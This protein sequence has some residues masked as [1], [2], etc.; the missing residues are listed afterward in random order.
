MHSKLRPFVIEIV[1]C[2]PN[3]LVVMEIPVS[4]DESIDYEASSND[5]EIDQYHHFDD[6]YYHEFKKPGTYRISFTGNLH[7][8][9]IRDGVEPYYRDDDYFYNDRA[10][11][12]EKYHYYIRDVC[13]WGSIEWH[14]MEN[15]FMNCRELNISAKDA[16][17][18]LQV[19]D[20]TNMFSNARKMNSS[21]NHWDV[22]HVEYMFGVFR[23]AV[24]FNQPLDNWDIS[25][26][27]DIA[28][29]FEDAF[30]FNQNING[31]NTSKVRF[32]NCAFKN[33]R[34]YNQP[35]DKWDVSQVHDMH[36][37]FENARS[38]NQPVNSWNVS[39]NVYMN[40]MF[41]EAQAFNQPLDNWDVSHVA[42]MSYMFCGAES[43]NQSVN[44][45]NVSRV[46]DM[47]RMF[48]L[49]RSFNQPLDKW[50]VSHV[51]SMKEMFSGALSFNQP[52]NTWDV[53]HVDEMD[54]MFNHATSFNQPL[55]DWDV[56]GVSEMQGM[57]CRAESFNQPLN[58][59]D[60]SRVENMSG[61]FCLAESFNQP[62]NKWDVSGVLNMSEM[63]RGAHS[64]GQLLT[65]WHISQDNLPIKMFNPKRHDLWSALERPAWIL[66]ILLNLIFKGKKFASVTYE[67]LSQ[68]SPIIV[69]HPRSGMNLFIFVKG[70]D[71]FYHDVALEPENNPDILYTEVEYVSGKQ[72]YEM[73]DWIYVLQH[74]CIYSEV[75]YG[76]ESRLDTDTLMGLV[77]D[78]HEH[79]RFYD[80]SD[81]QVAPWCSPVEVPPTGPNHYRDPKVFQVVVSD[82]KVTLEKMNFYEFQSIRFADLK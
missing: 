31:W 68:L 33:A 48:A 81:C 52:L 74:P 75:E 12:D 32:M 13:Q 45:W 37:M 78:R 60:V 23:G 72:W 15:M 50:D 18:L 73:M 4:S 8:I 46:E 38:F 9:Y 70:A 6:N 67:C 11:L 22:S 16:P 35:L 61:M 77:H 63:F 40:Y 5:E 17:D 39:N 1:V 43:F 82:K 55:N 79:F 2:R 25:N 76:H 29:I 20:M 42:D 36:E 71:G 57:F 14:S 30:S 49:A 58:N 26:V 34:N 44:S 53:S 19:R 59:W 21:L 64:F 41:C 62:L 47:R 65:S 69:I 7:Q 66:S 56:S 54:G 51:W 3:T 10:S 80:V 27:S 28:H 24:N